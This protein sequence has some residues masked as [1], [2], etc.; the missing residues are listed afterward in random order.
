MLRP[1]IIPCLLIQDGGLVKTVKFKDP[2]YVGDP[3]NAVKIF[4]EKEADELIV[5]DIDATANAVEPNYA[6]IAKLAAEC[7]MPLCYGGGIRTAQQ[8][9][10]I[11]ALG[12]EKVAIS[13]AAFENPQ[14]ISQIA[15]E[16]GRQ[17]VVVVLDHKA[18]LLSKQ[19]EVWTHN[20]TRNTKRSVIEAAQEF[21]KLGA[22]EIVLNSIENDGKMKGYDVE[23]A[24]KLREAVRI[25]ITILGGGGSL[26]D[27]RSVVAA[28]GVVGV[29]AGSFFVFKGAYRAVL[30]SYPSAQQKD[31]IIYSALRAR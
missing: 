24:I 18:R 13:S 31:D 15:E 20:G 30:I 22:G 16:I 8:A 27:M 26:E 1:R 4:N 14:L 19:Q 2:K 11:I 6:Q 5:I 3:I 17:S 28:C 12:V 21:E 10:N 29:A 23:L 7:R 9:K 25:P